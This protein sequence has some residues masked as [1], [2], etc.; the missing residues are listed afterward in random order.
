MNTLMDRLSTAQSAARRPRHAVAPSPRPPDLSKMADLATFEA[1]VLPQLDTLYRVGRRLTGETADAEDLVQET[2]LR[3]WRGWGSFTT[4]SNV[5]AWLLTILRNTFVSRWRSTKREGTTVSLD[6]A[7]PHA[8]YRAVGGQ[9]PEGSFFERVVDAQVVAAVESLPEEFREALILSDLEGLPYAEVA[10][11]LAIPIGT[12]KSR[13][14]RARR[15]LQ[16]QLHDHAVE[17]GILKATP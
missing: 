4:G 14:F 8:I 1:E 10:E 13:L 15:L 7:D 6:D 3:A 12:V 11:V 5:R 17:L 9:D 16:R 2:L